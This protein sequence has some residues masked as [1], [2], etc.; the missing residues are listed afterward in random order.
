MS[1]FKLAAA[2]YGKDK[3][4]VFRVIRPSLLG[5]QHQVVEYNVCL[6]VEGDIDTSY[7]Q[8]DNSCVVATDSMK[9]IVYVL[10]K[11]SPHVASPERFALH[12]ALHVVQKYAHIH[13][14]TVDIES[15]KWSRIPVQGVEHKHSFVRDGEEKRLTSVEVSE[16]EGKQKLAVKVTSGLKDLL[17][18]KSTGSAFEGFIRDEY[19]T[20]KEVKDR[21]FS[22]AV[23][24]SYTL[25]VSAIGGVDD[26]AQTEVEVQFDRVAASVKEITLEVFATDESASVQATLFKMGG[27]ILSKNPSVGSVSYKLPN[28]HYIPVDLGFVGLG[29]TLAEDA[30]VFCPIAGPSGLI[31]ATVS[32]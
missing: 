11:T 5:G 8:A 19:T 24:L 10:A 25:N 23:N 15:L 7:T 17:V 12:I 31:T 26:L 2:R 13:K 18:L 4:R 20:L 28:K 16:L 30:E 9:N 27:K 1:E 32:R 3:I 21:I 29:N 14:A 22:T 6:L